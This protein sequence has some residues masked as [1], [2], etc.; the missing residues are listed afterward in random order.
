LLQ[1][2]I[3][4]RL[5]GSL[6]NAV[7]GRQDCAQWLERAERSGFFLEALDS[8][9]QWYRY[10]ALFAETMRA[11]AT[12]RLGEEELRHLSLKAS[13]WY[14]EHSM[15][16]EAIEAA[17]HAQ[18]SE[19]AACLIEG[20]HESTYFSEQ[21]TLLRWLKQLPEPLLQAHPALCFRYALALYISEDVDITQLRT[22]EIEALLQMAEEGWRKLENMPDVGILYAFRTTLAVIQGR[23][24]SAVAYAKQALQYLPLPTEPGSDQMQKQPSEWVDWRCGCLVALGQDAM[25]SG[26]FEQARQFILEAHTLSWTNIDRTFT[27]TTRRMLGEISFELGELHQARE[28]YQQ[29]LANTEEELD[30]GEDVVHALSICGLAQ[31]CYEWNQL[32]MAE[33]LAGEAANYNYTGYLLH[34]EEEGRTSG[35]LL[36]LR[37]LHARGEVVLA[38]QQLSALFAR[39]QASSIPNIGHLIPDV[40]AWQARLQMS[41]G[42]LFAARRTLNILTS[43]EK[44]LYPLQLETLRLL[45]ARLLLARGEAAA[46]LHS[47]GQLLI[48]ALEGKHLIR[49]L[50]IQLLIALAHA[51]DGQEQKAR[52]WL[53]EVLSQA[54]TEGFLRLFLDEG[55]PLAT[56][57]RSLLPTLTE[58]PLRSYARSI[59]HAFADPHSIGKNSTA[60]PLLEPL[61]AQEQRVLTLLI[62]GRSNP[63][64]AQELIV[65]VNTVKGHVKNLYRKL[66]VNNRVQAGEIARQLKLV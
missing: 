20:L 26:C 57:L 22:E 18:E 58:K 7:T 34:W 6:C 13:R 27:R 60:S 16:V 30:R 46:A 31:L 35:E 14:E 51:A 21:H 10:H 48:T 38:Q 2:S 49:A 1:T 56:L 64:I 53:Y 65:S 39:L 63:E 3:L 25:R 61:S 36:R 17:L 37:V 42:D 52:Q 29:T 19:H 41:D 66:N 44:E 47:L 12:R 4:S 50:E 11:E 55:E 32:E 40:L 9:G 62:A 23:D 45:R 8:T 24:A 28:Y 33:Q 5:T 15:T 54:R 59:L 43:H